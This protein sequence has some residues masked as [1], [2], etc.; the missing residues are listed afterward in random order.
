MTFVPA[1]FLIGFSPAAWVLQGGFRH[2]FSCTGSFPAMISRVPP[3]A[4]T[5][6]KERTLG[7]GRGG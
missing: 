1:A 5:I 3:P 7:N 4:I 6:N 2:R